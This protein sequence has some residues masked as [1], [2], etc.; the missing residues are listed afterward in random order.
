MPVQHEP[1]LRRALCAAYGME[2]GREA[3]AEA[4]AYAREHWRRLRVT[5]NPAGCPLESR[6][7]WL[8]RAG[9]SERCGR[10]VAYE[11]DQ[12]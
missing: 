1:R 9:G 6:S 2:L 4:L 8:C 10:M 12:W 7:T 3:T 11:V 5:D